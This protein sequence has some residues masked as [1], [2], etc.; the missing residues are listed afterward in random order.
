[1]SG[2]Y[3]VEFGQDFAAIDRELRREDDRL[4]LTWEIDPR[5]NQKVYR[6]LCEVAGDKP[7]V[8]IAEWRDELG[9]PLPL[10]SGILERVRSQR[11]R[12]GVAA[13][14][15][16]ASNEAMIEAA[17]RESDEAMDE[18]AEDVGPRI[19]GKRSAVLH[20]GHHLRRSRDQRRA[21]GE[22]V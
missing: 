3:V 17:I 21:R 15:A 22:N 7:S 9:R 4:F 18:I 19:A 16:F 12:G 2:L 20:R 5:Y 13:Q 10:S 8:C 11:A 6:V 14:E 1:M